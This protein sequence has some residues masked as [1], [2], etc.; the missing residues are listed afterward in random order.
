MVGGD[1]P[2]FGQIEK[3]RSTLQA[4]DGACHFIFVCLTLRVKVCQNVCV[5]ACLGGGYGFMHTKRM[6]KTFL[7]YKREK[8]I[9]FSLLSV[10]IVMNW[11]IMLELLCSMPDRFPV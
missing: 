7:M 10:A 6:K 3:Y 5:C 11:F 8:V 4:Q 1:T 2:L 9:F